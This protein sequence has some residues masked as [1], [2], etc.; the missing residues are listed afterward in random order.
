MNAD[1]IFAP[2]IAPH[3]SP[4]GLAPFSV[5]RK[6]FVLRVGGGGVVLAA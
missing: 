5:D 2:A 3:A 6:G 4:P 1:I